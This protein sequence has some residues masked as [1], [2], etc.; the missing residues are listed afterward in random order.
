MSD[1][2]VSSSFTADV[3]AASVSPKK[4]DVTDVTVISVAML[5]NP[6]VK[7]ALTPSLPKVLFR[8]VFPR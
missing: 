2:S 4:A 1:L 7:L 3:L 5:P 6:V 8:F